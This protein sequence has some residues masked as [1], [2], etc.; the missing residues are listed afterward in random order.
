MRNT[1]AAL[2][3]FL[4]GCAATT[5]I[6]NS[7]KDPNFKGQLSF[8]KIAVMAIAKDESTRRTA[9]DE[10]VKIIGAEKAVASHTL[11]PAEELKNVEKAK[12]EFKKVGADGL[13]TIRPVD[14]QKEVNYVPSS[15][16]GPINSP[17]GYSAYGWDRAYEP[18]Y[19]TT[20]TIVQL[21][22]N[23]YSITD[24][25]LIWSGKSQTLNP[26][27]IPYEVKNL[28]QAVRTQLKKEQLL[29]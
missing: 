26:V 14:T 3:F 2:T 27:D 10:L 9:E 6:T 20:D 18:G 17:W 12:A 19:I 29:P 11:L 16:A 28:A 24:E 25:K 21:E 5:Q 22:T 7:W 15:V 13:V 23:I 8:K 4:A 1:F